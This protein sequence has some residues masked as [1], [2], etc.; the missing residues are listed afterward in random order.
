MKKL[1]LC[2]FIL[3]GV[4]FSN[5]QS[6]I[7]AEGHRLLR[8]YKMI[9]KNRITP[10]CVSPMQIDAYNRV[11]SEN[12]SAIVKLSA[13]ATVADIEAA[14]VEVLS[15][16][17]NLAIVSLPISK[18]EE[19]A[20]NNAVRKMEFGV[21]KSVHLD[22]ARNVSNTTWAH[23]VLALDHAYT[24]AGVVVGCMDIGIEP[25]HIAFMNSDQ[26][27]TRVKRVWSF[28]GQDGTSTEYKT[29]EDIAAFTY[30]FNSETHGTHVA[31]ILA[32]GYESRTLP[33]Y[34]VAKGADIALSGGQLSDANIL[35]G[36][37][38]I[39]KYAE[40][41]EQ[42][43]V[44]NLSLGY[45]VGPHDG[46][47]LFCQYLT[48]YGKRAAVCVSAGNEGDLNI[49]LKKKF[50]EMDKQLKSFVVENTYEGLHAG[51]IEVWSDSEKP[52]AVTLMVYDVVNNVVT[53]QMPT[54]NKVTDVGNLMGWQYI[55]NGGQ[56]EEGDISNANFD[57]A[58]KGSQGS[59]MGYAAT[60]DANNNRFNVQ[61]DYYLQ[62]TTANTGNYVFAV[63]VDG[64]PGQQ[65]EAYTSG[66]YS[67]FSTKGLAGWDEASKDGTISGMACAENVISV[68]SFNSRTYT[69]NGFNEPVNEVTT[70]SSYGTLLDG[71]E[72][73]HICAPGCM[74]YSSM[75]SYYAK[76][77][78]DNKYAA[79]SDFGLKTTVNGKTYYW[80]GMAGTS[81]AS[82]YM[83]G[84]IA[85]W[86]E[87][88]PNL[89]YRD[90]VEIA[91][92][93]AK[94]DSY[95][96]SSANPVKWG[97]GKL[98]VFAGLKLAIESIAGIEETLTD[99]K[100]FILSSDGDN[101]YDVFVAGES[102]LTAT[103]YNMA[104]QPVLQASAQG[105]SVALDASV[106]EKG[107]YVLY[108]Q[109]SDTKYSKRIL[110]K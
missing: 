92:N 102:T 62:N 54:V 24:G 18:V 52:V 42:P 107:V 63:V 47:E 97:A 11:Q 35:L 34:G 45:N 90:I 103:M 26:S 37:E 75:S 46:S 110:V 20:A 83:A 28:M 89:K 31:G 88:N 15:S 81:M 53:Y 93:S 61:I 78:V 79:E 87:A 69:G 51:S 82:P 48:E 55:S 105:E 80:T 77:L 19:F 9:Q 74:I 56:Y 7:D 43:V 91:Q 5:A 44:V 49:A 72:L 96:T 16:Q 36:V 14:G 4:L 29:P 38:N 86:L 76:Y 64:E 40:S 60:V 33:Y 22:K 17:G 106:L 98:D 109:G 12:V 101:Q 6:K 39:I 84:A 8:T 104:G 100:R 41:Q 30:D 57:M 71:R 3:G 59:F 1:Y 108:V 58:F 85:L 2:L 67:D 65:V 73:P 25:N 68:G 23:S 13:G 10:S 94:K 66:L 27:A 99:D 70:F 50:T 95:V 32:G 21:K